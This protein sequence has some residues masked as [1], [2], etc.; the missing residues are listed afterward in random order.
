MTCMGFLA[1]ALAGEDF[2]VGGMVAKACG[3]CGG[4]SVAVSVAG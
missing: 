2:L 4:Y 1:G 3:E